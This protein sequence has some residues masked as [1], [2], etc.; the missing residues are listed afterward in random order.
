MKPAI[1]GSKENLAPIAQVSVQHTVGNAAAVAVAFAVT[2]S[3]STIAAVV[4]T[5]R[6]FG[7]NGETVTQG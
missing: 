6:T 3:A 1:A 7:D 4:L 2:F 5:A